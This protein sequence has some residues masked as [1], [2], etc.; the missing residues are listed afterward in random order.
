LKLFDLSRYNTFIVAK[1]EKGLSQILGHYL[2]AGIR[3]NPQVFR[4]YVLLVNGCWFSHLGRPNSDDGPLL[5][6]GGENGNGTGGISFAEF[7]HGRDCL[8]AKL[9][10][11]LTELC[12]QW[13]KSRVKAGFSD[14][15]DGLVQ[16]PNSTPRP[17]GG[18]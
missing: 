3:G 12:A 8:V 16:N 9:D 15:S 6:H 1:K 2:Q 14:P 4:T 18:N 10:D 5:A 17:C 13:H 7:C 11:H